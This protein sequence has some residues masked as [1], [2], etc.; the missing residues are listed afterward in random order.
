MPRLALPCRASPRQATPG[1]AS[2]RRGLAPLCLLA[3][4]FLLPVMP[5]HATPNLARPCLV[6]GRSGLEPECLPVAP[7]QTPCHAAPRPAWTLLAMPNRA[8]VPRTRTGR[9]CQPPIRSLLAV[10]S[11]ALPCIASTS[12]VHL[13]SSSLRCFDSRSSAENTGRL[14]PPISAAARGRFDAIRS[15][16]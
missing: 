11:Q 7:P 13:P 14:R 12:H 5:R 8:R 2:G 6:R 1:L 3:A 9:V 15:R 10:H 16:S 4:H